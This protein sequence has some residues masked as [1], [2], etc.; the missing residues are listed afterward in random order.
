M[1]NPESD[2]ATPI[3]E[4]TIVNDFLP[5][6]QELTSGMHS[7]RRAKDTMEKTGGGDQ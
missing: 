6:P 2:P 4:V 7:G 3:G 1:P 5:T